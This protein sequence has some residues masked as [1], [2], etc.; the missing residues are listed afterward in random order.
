MVSAH[1]VTPKL[2][3]V[4]DNATSASS[5]GEKTGAGP[6]RRAPSAAY[7][8]GEGRAVVLD[9]THPDRPPY[10]FEGTAAQIWAGVDGTRTEQQL[11]RH[12]AESFDAPVEVVEADVAEFVGRL[13]E[14]GLVAGVDS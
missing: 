6:L 5:E 9:L 4:V 13:R 10:V 8:V 2:G 14:L 1:G 12:L 11:A 7:V 3:V